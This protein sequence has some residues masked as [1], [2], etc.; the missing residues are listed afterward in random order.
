MFLPSNLHTSIENILKDANLK[1][2]KESST[3]IT[4]LY[5]EGGSLYREEDLFT[6]LTVRLPAT[7]ASIHTVLSQTPFPITSLLDLGA[8]PG[9]GWWAAHSIWGEIAATCVE[10]ESTFIELGK[11]LGCPAYVLG[12]IERITSYKPHDLALFGYSYGELID[13]NLEP[14]WEAAKCVVIVEPGTPRGFQNMLKAREQLIKLGGH[15]LA[16]CPHSK[17][18]P[19]PKWCHFSVR[20]E[21]S[22][23]HRQAKQASLPYEDEKYSYVIVTKEPLNSHTPRILST[24]EKRTGHVNLELCT[25]DGIEKRTVS[26][27]NKDLYKQARKAKWG[28]L[29]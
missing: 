22:Q 13:F 7:Y 27:R 14:V 20:V 28:D 4:D 9:T 16:P 24:P 23:L 8:G 5:R 15:V 29:F 25:V 17:P 11:K 26:K 18:C 10:R 21:R 6:Y 1:E 19:H 2:L 3:Q 12:D